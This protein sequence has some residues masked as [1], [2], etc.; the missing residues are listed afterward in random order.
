MRFVLFNIAIVISLVY[1]FKGGELPL[2]GLKA[3]FER[4][5]TEVTQ[6][7][8]PAEPQAPAALKQDAKPAPKIELASQG[9]GHGY[10]TIQEP[11]P[12]PKPQP[13]PKTKTSIDT[14]PSQATQ[15]P[16]AREIAHRPQPKKAPKGEAIGDE[17]VAKLPAVPPVQPALPELASRTPDPVAKRRA[18]VLAEGAP[19]K[20]APTAQVHRA[21]AL[22]AGTSLMSA[23][24]RI[25]E[26]DALADEMELLFIEKVGG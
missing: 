19:V 24:E 8:K 10:D 7:V 9:S 6:L 21:V 26:L 3:Q 2:A 11:A 20:A 4:A 5:K 1:L 13:K 12:K 16:A 14:E 17:K 15:L 23:G 25:R 22:K 18:E